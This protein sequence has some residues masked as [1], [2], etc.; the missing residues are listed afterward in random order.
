MDKNTNRITF[1]ILVGACVVGSVFVIPFQIGLSPALADLGI[2]LYFA[3]FIQGLVLFSIVTFFGL[4]LARKVGFTLPILEGEHK[5][6]NFVAIL[7]PSILWGVLSG[8]L[9][10]LLALPFGDIT[11]DLLK[12]E[13]AVPIWAGFLASFYGG[14]AEEV[15]MRLFV[16][17]LLTWIFMKIKLSRDTSIQVAIIIS[18]V[19]FGLGHLPITGALT[20]ITAVVVARAVL[21]NGIGAIIFSLLYWKNGL[22]SAMIAHFSADIVLHV[23]TPSIARLLMSA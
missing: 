10:I 22:E 20:D 3:A 2:E 12:A 11:F 18:A 15:L 1:S 8:V 7:K 9:I 17:S 6:E 4:I 14:I 13:M 23:I 5:R 19:L 21:L 16:M